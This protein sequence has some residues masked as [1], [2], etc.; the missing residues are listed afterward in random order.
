MSPILPSQSTKVPASQLT[1]V[2]SQSTKKL[3]QSKR[4]PSSP[5]KCPFSQ[6]KC[7]CEYS[8][9]FVVKWPSEN[10]PHAP[11]NIIKD[12][13]RTFRRHC[14]CI[15][16]YTSQTDCCTRT[17]DVVYLIDAT[18]SDGQ[19]KDTFHNQIDFLETLTRSLH[20]G[21]GSRVSFFLLLS[22]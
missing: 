17:L 21:D 9:L 18:D 7:P 5:K 6:Q 19:T 10:W 14:Q 2:A 20:V 3:F 13:L 4:Y 1:K 8:V 22:F 16:D 11:R 15:E 12:P